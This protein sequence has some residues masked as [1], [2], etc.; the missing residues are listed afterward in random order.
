MATEASTEV[1][2]DVSTDVF[3]DLPQLMTRKQAAAVLGLTEAALSQMAT[4]GEGPKYVRA[5]RSVRYRTTDLAEWIDSRVVDPAYRTNP[6]AQPESPATTIVAVTRSKRGG[7]LDCGH[8]IPPGG[9]IFK[10]DDGSRGPQTSHGNGRG[11]WI[12]ARCALDA[13]D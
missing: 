4:R 1:P 3:A 7:L 10:V 11:A 9:Q 2:A 5:G 13:V 12:C 6:A 8:R